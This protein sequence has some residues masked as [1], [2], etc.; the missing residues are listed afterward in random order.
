MFYVLKKKKKLTAE[1]YVTKIIIHFGYYTFYVESIGTSTPSA[2]T[3]AR[4]SYEVSI[5]YHP[6]REEEIE[7][8]KEKHNVIRQEGNK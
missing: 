6:Q 5:I 3:H 4:G 8:W 7:E 1:F 2:S